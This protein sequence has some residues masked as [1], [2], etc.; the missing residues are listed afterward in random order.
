MSYC[1]R[2]V[3]RNAWRASSVRRF[4]DFPYAG[5]A[6][7]RVRGE[8]GSGRYAARRE[9]RRQREI[10]RLPPEVRAVVAGAVG[11]IKRATQRTQ[12]KGG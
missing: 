4:V 5:R 9:Q 12:G 1:D 8:R 2:I 6:K 10:A 11:A 3:N 7:N